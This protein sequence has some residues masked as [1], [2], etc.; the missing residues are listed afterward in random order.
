[1]QGLKKELEVVKEEKRRLEGQLEVDG[2]E[3]TVERQ[4]MQK[5]YNDRMQIKEM[6]LKEAK[7]AKHELQVQSKSTVS[8]LEVVQ[9][10]LEEAT[11]HNE[12]LE[13]MRQSANG[14]HSELVERLAILER[15]KADLMKVNDASEEEVKCLKDKLDRKQ[16]DFDTR[17]NEVQT[18]NKEL[19]TQNEEVIQQLQTD[20]DEAEYRLDDANRTMEVMQSPKSKEAME[21]TYSQEVEVLRTEL[22]G[23]KQL[24]KQMNETNDD[25][26]SQL[27]QSK[28]ENGTLMVQIQ[29]LEVKIEEGKVP[30]AELESENTVIAAQL[31]DRTKELKKSQQQLEELAV[32]NEQAL[33]KLDEKENELLQ[34][35]DEMEG[36]SKELV[37]M[38]SKLNSVTSEKESLLSEN[39]SLAMELN[40]VQDQVSQLQ[41]Q[42]GSLK[43]D[44]AKSQQ[45]AE[46]LSHQKNESDQK[47]H[48]LSNQ[49]QS[50]TT[51]LE[52]AQGTISSLEDKLRAKNEYCE[53]FE[54]IEKKLICEK[55]VLNEIRRTLHNKVIQLTG[56][57]RVYIRVRP[58]ISSEQQLAATLATRPSSASGRPSSRGSIASASSSQQQQQQQ[59]ECFHFPGVADR[60]ISGAS[61]SPNYTSF[62]D[63]SKQTI[64]L[65]EPHRD[66][67]GLNPRRKKWKYGFDK[68]FN[69]VNDQAD[70]WVGAEPLVQSAIDGHKV[71]M[72]AYGQTSSG[73]THTM[74]GDSVNRGL[75]PRAVEKLFASKKEIERSFA[76]NVSVSIK[77]ELLEIYNEDVFD[78]L[79]AEAGPKGQKIKIRLNSNEAVN[80][81]VVEASSQDEVQGVLQL[82]QQRRCVKATK[83]NSES[84]RSHLLFTVRFELS[85]LTNEEMNRQGVL[86]IVDLAGSERLDK[87]GSQGTLLTEAKHIN[88]SLSALSHVIQKLQEKSEHI[89]YRD[90]KLTY[91]L[92]DSLGGDSKTLCIVCC[93]PHQ[94]HFNESLNSIRFAANASKVELKQ[95]NKVDV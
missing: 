95:G 16:N 79:D 21:S 59:E 29:D 91:L 1:V 22:K 5:E 39:E 35:V 17:L 42:V 4:R 52:V 47:L 28:D 25:L 27:G 46:S 48:E 50:L 69:P 10:K 13:V 2:T 64:E 83:S 20:L 7:E 26:E 3:W 53:Q 6:E 32:E 78:L 58:L 71:C 94:A 30:I 15:E 11:R 54:T 62:S 18:E 77:V 92:R 87:S 60:K 12:E 49:L 82:A 86:H 93:S 14:S 41:S 90:S 51:H 74:I 44:L 70:V 40:E 88:T 34:A 72:F 36:Q 76:G 81:V 66:R 56:N 8:E 68:V 61:K 38:E 57:I 37:E 80:N 33:T 55:N 19:L 89:P 84:S 67:G 73:K 63:L 75:I 24:L 85:S 23:M 43:D 65:T 9:A 45:Q 31:N